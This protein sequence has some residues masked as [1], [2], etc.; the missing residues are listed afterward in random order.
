M[1]SVAVG[2]VIKSGNQIKIKANLGGQLVNILMDTGAA[3]SCTNIPLPLSARTIQIKGIGDGLMIAT[4]M[5][6]VKLDLGMVVLNEPFWYLPDNSEGT[7]LGMDIMRKH[8][9][10]IHCFEKQIEVQTNKAVKKSHASEPC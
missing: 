6:R 4:Q 1:A 8:G 5:Q 3:C 2:S 7:V 10:V 9:F